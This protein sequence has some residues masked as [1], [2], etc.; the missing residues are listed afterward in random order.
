[1]VAMEMKPVRVVTSERSIMVVTMVT[2]SLQIL[3]LLQKL[4]C[5]TCFVGLDPRLGLFLLLLQVPQYQSYW[6][7]LELDLTLDL[8]LPRMTQ[9]F[10]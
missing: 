8:D 6:T 7:C 10:D 1:M 9:D 4:D 2:D 5:Q 3:T